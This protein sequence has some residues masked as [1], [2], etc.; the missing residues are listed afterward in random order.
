M[1]SDAEQIERIKKEVEYYGLTEFVFPQTLRRLKTVD[2]CNWE[3]EAKRVK[4]G[5]LY[6]LTNNGKTALKSKESSTIGILREENK[7][8]LK[9]LS[10]PVLVYIVKIDELAAADTYDA[11]GFANVDYLWEKCGLYVAGSVGLHQDGSLKVDGVTVDKS[12]SKAAVG[13]LFCKGNRLLFSL[14]VEDKTVSVA[15]KRP[16][17]LEFVEV[18]QDINWKHISN[19]A[20]Y[21]CIC[22]RKTGT[23]ITIED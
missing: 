17:D 22:F 5:S 3:P 7:R 14:N 18:Y 19:S 15:V 10:S 2:N 9:S 11:I 12:A 13:M 23:K 16:D 21:F 8:V 20:V 6:T 4:W 1:P